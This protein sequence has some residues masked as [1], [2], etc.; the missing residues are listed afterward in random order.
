MARRRRFALGDTTYHV[1]NRSSGRRRI[2]Y[3]RGDYEAFLRT[4][5]EAQERTDMRVLAY[6]IMPNHWHLVVWPHQDGDVS[7]FA[8][9][10]TQT[11]TQRYNTSRNIVGLGPLYQGRFKSF[12]VQRD[13]HL[14]WVCRYVEANARVA[15]L[16]EDAADWPW[17]SA[18]QRRDQTNPVRLVDEWP[19]PRP[20]DWNQRL[21]QAT[22]RAVVLALRTVLQHQQPYG[23]REWACAMR[24]GS[25]PVSEGV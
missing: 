8:G 1:L 6:C 24:R 23:N 20:P 3:T 22:D 16:L 10:L 15:F 12:P 4:L 17:G 11:H 2:F 9:W 18:C 5:R 21:N 19:V 14:L 13:V 25:D 7:R